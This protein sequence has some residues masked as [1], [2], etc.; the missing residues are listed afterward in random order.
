MNP[1][2]I[3]ILAAVAGLIVLGV[4]A[5]TVLRANRDGEPPVPQSPRLLAQRDFL[6]DTDVAAPEHAQVVPPPSA[7]ATVVKR[8]A[9]E[10]SK[11]LP[12]KLKL[13]SATLVANEKMDRAHTC[14]GRN[15]SPALSWSD[16]PRDTKSM[17]VLFERL[18]EKGGTP[19]QWSVYN[20][21]AKAGALGAN[22]PKTPNLP[23]GMGQGVNDL[24]GNIGY[25]GPCIA[26]GQA[27]YKLRLFALD[28]MP[29]LPGGAKRD[30]LI[31]MMNGHV[32]DAA[33]MPLMYF[34]RL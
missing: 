25:V 24:V 1:K 20:I 16:A 3:R 2:L 14:N 34:Y 12:N 17:V 19:L 8:A 7:P 11:R 22:L 23:E 9:L 27:N 6:E 4:M 30:D 21:S 5:I 10:S 32:L 13:I 15:A 26:K 33:E 31:T 18:D 29:N 28:I